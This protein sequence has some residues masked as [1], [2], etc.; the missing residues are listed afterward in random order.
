MST[1]DTSTRLLAWARLPLN[2]QASFGLCGS[3][4]RALLARSRKRRR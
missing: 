2:P 4:S 3:M 1:P